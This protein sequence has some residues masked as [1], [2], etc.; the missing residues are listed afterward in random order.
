MDKIETFKTLLPLIPEQYRRPLMIYIH[1]EEIMRLV[2]SMQQCMRGNFLQSPENCDINKI[3][4]SFSGK[5]S[6]ES[7]DLIKSLVP[8]M[9]NGG[10]NFSDILSN[11]MFSKNKKSDDE[12]EFESHNNET[13]DIDNI[14]KE[15]LEENK[16]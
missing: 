10:L 16:N 13:D 6:S 11:N 2:N 7:G 8:L 9:A 14:F 3:I 1:I 5:S 4:E 12:N 15:F